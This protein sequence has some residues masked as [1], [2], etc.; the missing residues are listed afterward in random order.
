METWRKQ[1]AIVCGGIAILTGYRVVK[2]VAY[3]TTDQSDRT[4]FLVWMIILTTIF[5]ALAAV[6]YRLELAARRQRK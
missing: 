5:G 6:F 1:V 2:A 4:S 3:P